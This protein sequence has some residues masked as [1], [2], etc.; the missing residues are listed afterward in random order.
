MKKTIA[1]V[2][3]LVMVLCAASALAAGS[4]ENKN[5]NSAT[6]T[7][8]T[9]QPV[10]ITK[11][12]D[13]AETTAIKQKIRDAQAAGNVLDAFPP[14]LVAQ[15][16][17]GYKVVNEMDTY[18]LTGDVS[19]ISSLTLNFKFATTFGEGEQVPLMLGIANG[20]STEWILVMGTG[21][22]DGSVEVILNAATL[23]KIGNNPFV[24]VP[25][26]K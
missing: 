18:Q 10:T 7:T 4:K 9:S 5:L 19:G 24:V 22:A 20:N 12:T 2:L 17:E 6:T 8:T 16:P 21:K 3:A 15:L 26:S 1:L 13:T 23:A 14:E 11:I 25:L